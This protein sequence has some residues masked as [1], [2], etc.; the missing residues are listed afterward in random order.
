MS[1]A[2]LIKDTCVNTYHYNM[3]HYNMYHCLKTEIGVQFLFGKCFQSVAK[4]AS[5]FCS[6]FSQM[7]DCFVFV[8]DE[9]SEFSSERKTD[10]SK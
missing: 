10:K 6:V 8:V 2:E 1:V 5:T 7:L 9:F 3:Y 4:R